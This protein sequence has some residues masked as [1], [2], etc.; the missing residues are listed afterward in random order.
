LNDA[1]E[2]Y[3]AETGEARREVEALRRE[4]ARRYDHLMTLVHEFR[5]PLT[6]LA[7]AVEILEDSLGPRLG[8]KEREFFDVIAVSLARLNQMLD[9]M[10]ELTALESREVELRYEATDVAALARDVLAEAEARAEVFDVKLN[11][12]R[13]EGGA[14]DV[15]CDPVLISRVLANMVSNAV[16]YNKAGGEVAVTLAVDG[17]R[18]RV[19]VADT[20]MGIPEEDFDKVF[21][22]FYRAPE[23]RQKRIAGTG[24]G[25]TIAKNIVELH[26]GEM[27]FASVLGE[28]STFTFEIPLRKPERSASAGNE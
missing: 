5:N 23:V 24:L 28:G 25:L 9:E 27:S 12:V 16:K 22:R 11:P 21:T 8:G 2:Q 13:L 6:A 15:E 10:L 26:G 20:G 14:P 19:D 7:G 4:N 18:L 3:G 17:D 1:T